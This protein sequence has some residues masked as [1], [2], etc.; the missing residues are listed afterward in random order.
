M[1]FNR[2]IANDQ[3]STAAIIS[4]VAAGVPPPTVLPSWLGHGGGNGSI[5]LALLDG[6]TM[7]QMQTF[8]GAVKQHLD[9]LRV[10]HGLTVVE[11]NGVY[12][13]V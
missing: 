11:T 12:R 4:A 10:E 1:T 7:D 3:Q 13:L 9:H 2:N 6:A 8:R 5:D